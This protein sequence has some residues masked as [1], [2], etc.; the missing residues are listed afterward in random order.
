MMQGVNEANTLTLS[1]AAKKYTSLGFAVTALHEASKAAY[2]D[3]WPQTATP[4]EHWN[5]N[6]R[7]N[8]GVNLHL[9]GL[10]SLDIDNLH[11]FKLAVTSIGLT[12][13]EGENPFW[14]TDTAGIKSGRPNRA[15]LIF[16]IPA[17]ETLTYHN[18]KWYDVGGDLHVVFELRAGEGYQDV[19]PPSIHPDI[20]PETGEHY[21][22]EWVGGSV[23]REMPPDLLLLWKNWQTFEPA[24][25][26]ADRFY[27][28]HQQQRKPLSRGRPR[29][30][31]TGKDIIGEWK[32]QQNLCQVLE[33]YG[34]EPKGSRYVR[35]GSH[36]GKPSVIVSGDGMTFY[37][38]SESDY[39][40]DGRQHNAF[41]LLLHFECN[42]NMQRAI[43]A[44]KRDLGILK[45]TD[46]DLLATAKKLLGEGE[47]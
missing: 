46:K 36:S 7:D 10:C 28:Q 9:S 37:T 40:A 18:L 33:S 15:K 14:E 8:I 35:P 12:P 41:D 43:E 27:L 45:I 32:Q 23:I 31:I 20:N 16:R 34:Y 5:A 2:L 30:N 25:K 38:F 13:N 4:A 44:V 3:N 11:E 6:P 17:G 42:D 29:K 47:Y 21:K 39:F 26:Q 1:E 22:Y 19:L 24:L